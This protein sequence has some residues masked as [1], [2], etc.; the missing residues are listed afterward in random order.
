[1]DISVGEFLQLHAES[2]RAQ[3]IPDI[4]EK[5]LIEANKLA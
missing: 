3:N 1:M 2:R 5:I 4:V